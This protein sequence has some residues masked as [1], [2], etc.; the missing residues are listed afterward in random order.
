MYISRPLKQLFQLNQAWSQLLESYPNMRTAVIEGVTKMLAC[1]TQVMGCKQYGCSN[2]NCQHIKY[3]TFTC[4]SKACSSCGHKQTEQWIAKMENILPDCE[5]QHI[6]FTMPKELWPIFASNRE[7]LNDICRLASESLLQLAKKR[8]IQIGI[9]AAIHTFGRQL[10]WNV[11]IHLSVTRGGIHKESGDWKDI[12]FAKEPVMK[13]WRYNLIQLIRRIPFSD[14]TLPENLASIIHD[15]ND[16]N[17][18]LSNAY[19]REWIV[20]FAEKTKEAIHTVKYLG[21]YIKRPPIAASKLKHYS[22]GDVTFRFLN[23]RNNKHETKVLNQK[24]MIQRIIRH[25]PE[26]HFRMIRYY[27]F[28]SNRTRGKELANVYAALNMQR[29]E[30]SQL[31]F[32]GMLKGFLNVDP[33]ECILCGCRMI[34]VQFHNGLRLPEL[35]KR[36]QEIAQ[37]KIVY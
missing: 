29:N 28:L 30:T 3:V 15:E 33:F 12:Y 37:M 27:G 6:T 31:T 17:T 7:L 4:K 32:A 19:N 26:K 16:W 22:G 10:N 21:R 18:M 13:A 34:F 25:I 14:I 20:H 8:K 11:H 9:F 2:P 23:H 36:A 1:G 35:V 24:T 5:W